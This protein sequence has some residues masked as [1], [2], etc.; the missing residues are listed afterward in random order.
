LELNTIPGL[1]YRSVLP[2]AAA[3]AG[4]NMQQLVDKFA[5][6]VMA[7]DPQKQSV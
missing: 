6:M 4:I 5:A 7:T 2:K 3:A 1:T